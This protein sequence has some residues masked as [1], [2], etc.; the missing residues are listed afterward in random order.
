MLKS[1]AER[2]RKYEGYLRANLA[3]RVPMRVSGR[4]VIAPDLLLG[5]PSLYFAAQLQ[6]VCKL[7]RSLSVLAYGATRVR[8]F[9]RGGLERVEAWVWWVRVT[10]CLEGVVKVVPIALLG[11]VRRTKQLLSGVQN[12]CAIFSSPGLVPWRGRNR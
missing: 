8:I 2:L 5:P 9:L 6:C 1:T 3:K 4:S 10:S 7:V 12:E 11:V